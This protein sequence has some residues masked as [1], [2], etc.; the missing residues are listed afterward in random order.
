MD[1]AALM[2]RVAGRLDG[3]EHHLKSADY[4]GHN[5]DH[6]QR[7]H[8]WRAELRWADLLVIDVLLDAMADR[9]IAR[10]WFS[11]ADADL[12]DASTEYGGLIRWDAEGELIARPYT[13]MLRDHDRKFIPPA[14]MTT[15]A[16]ASLAHYH[17][18]A[19]RYRN[20]RYAGPGRGD[21]ERVADRQRLNGL[22]LTFIDKDRLN[23]DFYRHGRVVVDLGT[24][25]R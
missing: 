1:R 2:R 15:D 22:V 21:L 25:R 6:P 11:Q 23:A 18:H 17:F 20:A 10:V 7:L 4:D 5:A 3:R 14:A 13:P 16:Y 9:A 8:D 12:E 24:L 19:Q